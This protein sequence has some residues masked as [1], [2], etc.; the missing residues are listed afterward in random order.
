MNLGDIWLV[1]IK[2]KKHARSWWKRQFQ[3][4]HQTQNNTNKHV[5]TSCLHKLGP[6]P[7]WGIK[8][9]EK[10]GHNLPTTS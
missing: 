6:L 10:G 5:V 4:R 2:E 3:S 7:V 8:R 1:I 9:E